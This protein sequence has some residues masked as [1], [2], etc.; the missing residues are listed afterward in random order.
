MSYRTTPLQT[1]FNRLDMVR[2]RIGILSLIGYKRDKRDK[3][4]KGIGG[5]LVDKKV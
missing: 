3:R 2:C 1:F 4:D 5:R